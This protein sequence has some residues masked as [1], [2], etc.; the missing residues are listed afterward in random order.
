[1]EWTDEEKALLSSEEAKYY[2]QT[3]DNVP[4]F[5]GFINSTTMARGDKKNLI[6][7]LEL[8]GL[9]EERAPA[10]KSQIFYVTGNTR[11]DTSWKPVEGEIVFA[12]GVTNCELLPAVMLKDKLVLPSTVATLGN[13]CFYKCYTPEIDLSD[14]AVTKI[15]FHCFDGNKRVEVIR[16]PKNCV[17]ISDRA[18]CYTDSLRS[19]YLPD[20]IQKIAGNAFAGVSAVI[21]TRNE[22]LRLYLKSRGLKVKGI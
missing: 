13:Y 17:S 6:Q 5:I 14:C 22:K 15:P 7:K 10:P 9:V 21:H 11:F 3:L 19:I 20:S 4:Q 18:F 2:L 1:M 16:L 12:P 8:L